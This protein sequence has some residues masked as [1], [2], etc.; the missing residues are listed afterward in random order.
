M[1]YEQAQA[2]LTGRN[3]DRKKL[4]NNTYLVRRDNGDFAVKLHD[5]DVVTYHADGT[6]TLSTGGW[7]T[8][9]TKARINEYSHAGISQRQG[10]WYMSDGSLYRDGLV[11]KANGEPVAPITTTEQNGYE[12]KLKEIK[13]DAKIYAKNY[14]EAL[15]AGAVG[16]PSGA[17]CWGCYFAINS[18]RYAQP[19]GA[20]H[21]RQ[22]MEEKYYVPSLLVNAGHAAGYQDFQIGLMGIGGHN[23]Y[24]DPETNIYKY[25]VKVLQKEL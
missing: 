18:E 20:D 1:D 19:M 10:V 23:L 8:V 21:I 22:H 3:K 25:I 12:A 7:Q 14:V 24:I 4:A 5:T 16:L 13:K 9:T 11:I 17:D 15:K 2:T 6:I